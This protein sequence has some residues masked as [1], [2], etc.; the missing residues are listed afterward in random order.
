MEESDGRIKRQTRY[1]Y[2]YTLMK[3]DLFERGIAD[4]SSFLSM[5]SECD[6]FP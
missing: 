1:K 3:R 2:I 5:H 4:E 6:I